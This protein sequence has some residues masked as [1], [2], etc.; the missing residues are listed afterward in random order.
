MIRVLAFLLLLLAAFLIYKGA[1]LLLA[2]D[3]KQGIQRLAYAISGFWIGL[4]LLIIM[5][6]KKFN[7]SMIDQDEWM[8]WLMFALLPNILF[9]TIIWILKGL[10]KDMPED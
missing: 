8:G 3:V 5:A 10:N 4:P 9:W 1:L 2:R 7:I 6:Q